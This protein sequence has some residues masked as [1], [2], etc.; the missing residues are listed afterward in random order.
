MKIMH[1]ESPF[2]KLHANLFIMQYHLILLQSRKK[3]TDLKHEA[4]IAEDDC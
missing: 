4:G 3:G 1:K 2:Q